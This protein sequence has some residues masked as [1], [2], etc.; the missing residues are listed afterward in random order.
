M[1]IN[2][3]DIQEL[4]MGGIDAIDYRQYKAAFFSMPPEE[5]TK[6]KE[7]YLRHLKA[8]GVFNIYQELKMQSQFVEAH[9]DVSVHGDTIQ[10]HSHSFYELLY[11]CSGK[12]EYLLGTERYV[13]QK[14]DIIIIPP[15]LSHRPLVTMDRDEK[16]YERIAVWLST[17]F[18]D[19]CRE[20]LSEFTENHILHFG[21]GHWN[22]M[23][24]YFNRIYMESSQQ[25]KAYE[26]VLYGNALALMALLSRALSPGTHQAT[27]KGELLDEVISFIESHLGEKISLEETA[28]YFYVS[29]STLSKLFRSRLNES[30]Y[31]YV[32]QRRLIAAKQ[33]V[34]SGLSLNQASEQAGFCD[35]AAFYRAFRKEYRISPIQY[36]ELLRQ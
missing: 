7:H 20:L 33:L 11:I 30:F 19:S 14:G 5:R 3:I 10:L 16:C 9:R 35:Y 1:R 23:Y 29:Q 8:Q 24:D 4:L 25:R 28:R 2:S 12:T 22:T 27:E 13:V 34:D 36:R 15:N 18:A 32:T 6:L 31:K 17:A 26:S 21:N